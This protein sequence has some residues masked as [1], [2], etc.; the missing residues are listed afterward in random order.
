MIEELTKKL[1]GLKKKASWLKQLRDESNTST[2][3]YLKERNELNSRHSEL[4][5]RAKSE[6]KLRNEMNK[7]VAEH[8]ESKER[9]RKE[10]LE[11]V[12]EVKQFREQKQ[13]ITPP[14]RPPRK[15]A[16]Q[17]EKIEWKIQTTVLDVKKERELIKTVSELEKDLEEQKKHTNINSRIIETQTKI[18][19]LKS[20]VLLHNKEI[21][22]SAD[23]A[24]EHHT[25]MINLYD[26]AKQVKERADLVHKRFLEA[27]ELAND[28]HQK[29][30]EIRNQM[31]TAVQ[32]IHEQKSIQRKERFL[33]EEELIKEK[34]KKAYEKLK[35]GEKLTF[36][37]FS[38]LLEQGLI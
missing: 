7:R 19:T 2:K 31:R 20:N 14:H 10:I 23:V 21:A 25:N 32:K 26:D 16:R 17:I 4:I 37:E 22:E 8:K 6:Q 33:H 24:Q 12:K 11:L 36:D 28:Y 29:Y 34:T 1:D 3:E 9:L 30:L 27:K 35:E 38:M 15:L 13:G 18:E 5:S